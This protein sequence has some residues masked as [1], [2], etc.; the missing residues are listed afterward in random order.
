MY[1]FLKFVQHSGSS[2]K[3]KP[4]RGPE[5]LMGRRATFVATLAERV[6]NQERLRTSEVLNSDLLDVGLLDLVWEPSRAAS[7]LVNHTD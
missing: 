3:K 5:S 7:R 1:L 6:K 2:N 4:H